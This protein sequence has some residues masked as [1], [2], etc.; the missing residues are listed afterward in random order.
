MTLE[1][2]TLQSQ[3]P[4][5]GAA[6]AAAE[7]PDLCTNCRAPLAS[8]QEWC[9]ECGAGRTR[10]HSPPDWRIGVGIVAAII[11]AALIAFAIVLANLK[12]N[13]STGASTVTVTT[14]APAAATT[15]TAAPA[16][17]T[18]QGW[19]VGLSG[20]TVVLASSRTQTGA[21]AAAAQIAAA[22]TSVGV[23]DSSLHPSMRPGFWLVFSG[24][25]PSGP[26]AQAAAAALR[27]AGQPSA[28]ALRV[29]KPGGL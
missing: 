14:S 10:L 27:A 26:L 6:A 22:G 13:S 18:F 20:W 17:P 5:A 12:S 19:P 11:V 29:A 24:R 2:A 8:D 15:A 28:R 7:E 1:Q 25:Y 9:L 23:L 16:A 21:D 4:T 3:D